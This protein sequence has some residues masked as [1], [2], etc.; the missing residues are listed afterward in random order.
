MKSLTLFI[1]EIAKKEEHWKT[2]LS[3]GFSMSLSY[4]GCTARNGLSFLPS[5][6]EIIGQTVQSCSQM[7]L[8]LLPCKRGGSLGEAGTSGASIQVIYSDIMLQNSQRWYP[9]TG[10]QQARVCV[11][12]QMYRTGITDT[13]CR[14]CA[15]PRKVLLICRR[16]RQKSNTLGT[17]HTE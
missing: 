2:P 10:W 6:L 3:G 13:A 5:I 12:A 17:R 16:L 7:E 4:A 15:G 14:V 11:H 9:D 1:H 8:C